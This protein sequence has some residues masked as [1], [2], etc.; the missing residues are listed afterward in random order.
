[1]FVMSQPEG[2]LTNVIMT[3][4]TGSD[5]RANMQGLNHSVNNGIDQQFLMED[6]LFA[7]EH[8]ISQ[9][10][11]ELWADQKIDGRAVFSIRETYK[12]YKSRFVDI[13]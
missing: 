4:S 8:V 9:R 1:M 10:Q 5:A 3:N 13:Q 6:L 7:T 11:E 12:L 2:A